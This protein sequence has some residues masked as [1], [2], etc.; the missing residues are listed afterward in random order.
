MDN[1]D[2]NRHLFTEG[3]QERFVGKKV[4]RKEDSFSFLIDLKEGIRGL[5][6]TR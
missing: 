6:G 2:V 3:F 4:V 1:Y 5:S